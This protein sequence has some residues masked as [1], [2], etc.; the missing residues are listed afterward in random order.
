MRIGQ[1]HRPGLGAGAAL[2]VVVLA[3]AS[4]PAPGLAASVAAA[5]GS[6]M[7]ATAAIVSGSPPRHAG[8]ALRH[9]GASADQGPVPQP[10]GARRPRQPRLPGAGFGGVLVAA[11][12]T[13]L[14]AG[15]WLLMVTASRRLRR[16]SR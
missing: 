9:A 14:A 4:G 15:G 2:A 6:G 12:G 1:R 16:R 11:M 7:A 8:Y 10:Q 13:A 5:N 3:A